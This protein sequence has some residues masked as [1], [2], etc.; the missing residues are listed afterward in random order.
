LDFVTACDA[1]ASEKLLSAIEQSLFERHLFR[2]A[3][4]TKTTNATTNM[5]ARIFIALP[6][7]TTQSH[8]VF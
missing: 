1:K 2:R 4:A 6:R 3:A 8:F 5:K 7:T